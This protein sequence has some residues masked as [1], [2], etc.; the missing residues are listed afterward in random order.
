M[1]SIE[2]LQRIEE[3][4]RGYDLVMI[5]LRLSC[6][7]MIYEGTSKRQKSLLKEW[8]PEFSHCSC[9]LPDK[10]GSPTGLME[11]RGYGAISPM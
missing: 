4:Q 2:G 7:L 11:A 3:E 8:Q 10:I 6:N 1:C 9:C 5:W